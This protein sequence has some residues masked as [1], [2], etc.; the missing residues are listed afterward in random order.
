MS[1]EDISQLIEKKEKLEP[2][3][4]VPV[5]GDAFWNRP[6]VVLELVTRLESGASAS[7]FGLRRIGKSSIMKEVARHLRTKGHT[8]IFLNTEGMSGPGRLLVDL[9]RGLDPSL[10]D[11]ISTA[12]ANNGS[13]S[14]ALKQIATVLKKEPV[15]TANVEKDFRDFWEPL[16][17]TVERQLRD[18][19]ARV[20]VFIDELPFFLADQIEKGVDKQNIIDILATLRRWRQDSN[21]MAQVLCGSIGMAGFLRL[22]DIDRDHNNDAPGIYVGPLDQ[23]DACDFLDAV[24]KGQ[25]IEGWTDAIR[26]TV[27]AQAIEYYPSYLQEILLLLKTEALLTKYKHGEV[28]DEL[29]VDKLNDVVMPKIR[30]GFEV[31]LLNQFDKRLARLQNFNKEEDGAKDWSDIALDILRAIQTDGL[32][33]RADLD[34]RLAKVEITGKSAVDFVEVLR[35]DAFVVETEQGAYAFGDK[36]IETWLQRRHGAP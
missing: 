34:A 21:I 29:L 5:E 9:V 13:L 3:T 8:C 23:D 10:R 14:G 20:F 17:Q 22:H 24:A 19:D 30:K 32:M 1:E 36:I 2:K 28:N 31:D 16:T 12:W 33:T 4:G 26:D 18:T 25:S 27:I 15:D 35:E 11:Q 6:E 7:L